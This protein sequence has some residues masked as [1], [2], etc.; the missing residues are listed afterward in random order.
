MPGRPLPKRLTTNKQS[1]TS[2]DRTHIKVD[3]EMI[4]KRRGRSVVEHFKST[5]NICSMKDLKQYISSLSKDYVVSA[6]FRKA[7]E[8]VVLSRIETKKE[9]QSTKEKKTK[10]KK[11]NTTKTEKEKSDSNQKND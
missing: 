1:S 5:T 11:R 3:F 9:H 8:E 2:P 6:A 10:S 7:C 4:L